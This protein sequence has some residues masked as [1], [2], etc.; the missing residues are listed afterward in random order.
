[1]AE[2]VVWIDEDIARMGIWTEEE[3]RAVIASV[4][5]LLARSNLEAVGYSADYW[6]DHNPREDPPVILTIIYHVPQGQCNSLDEVGKSYAA[7]LTREYGGP[8]GIGWMLMRTNQLPPRRP[9]FT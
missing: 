9:Y 2:P 3:V 6:H 1:M 5:G 8:A 4:D 7:V